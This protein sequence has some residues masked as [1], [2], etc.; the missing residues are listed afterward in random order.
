MKYLLQMMYL[1]ISDI[2]W[3][4]HINRKNVFKFNSFDIRFIIICWFIKTYGR[5]QLRV[6]H[7]QNYQLTKKKSISKYKLT[8]VTF[9]VHR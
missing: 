5:L 9:I 4:N 7:K 3:F 2:S 1:G 8:C 6:V